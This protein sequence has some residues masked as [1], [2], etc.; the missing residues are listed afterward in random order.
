MFHSGTSTGNNLPVPKTLGEKSANFIQI[1][2]MMRLLL[3]ASSLVCCA[4]AAMPS[5]SNRFIAKL[6]L[7]S[8]LLCGLPLASTNAIAVDVSANVIYKSGKNPIPVD[9][10][11][12]TVGSKKDINFLRCMSNCKSKCQ[13]PGEGLAK[14]DCVQDCQD[15]CCDSYEQCSFKIKTSTIGNS[16]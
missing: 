2:S 8:S 11:D 7:S 15:Q 12:P 16:I 5:I 10:N 3:V 13:L 14:A 9:A 1:D 4:L 6:M